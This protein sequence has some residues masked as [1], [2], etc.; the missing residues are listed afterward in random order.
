M[1]HLSET[2]ENMNPALCGNK[3]IMKSG[4]PMRLW[5]MEP[6]HIRTAFCT[7]CH[8]CAEAMGVLLPA[9]QDKTITF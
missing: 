9:R 7:K 2:G 1:Y 3:N 8:E 4:H 5:N 6:T